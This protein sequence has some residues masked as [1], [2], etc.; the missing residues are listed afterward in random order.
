MIK[1]G[2]VVVL[3]AGSTNGDPLNIEMTS[4]EAVRC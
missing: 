4:G 3:A 2:A 1:R